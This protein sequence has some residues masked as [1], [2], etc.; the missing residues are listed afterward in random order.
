[1]VIASECHGTVGTPITSWKKWLCNILRVLH[2]IF[3]QTGA[4][5]RRKK[6]RK[7]GEREEGRNEEKEDGRLKDQEG[8]LVGRSLNEDTLPAD[9]TRTHIKDLK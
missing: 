6:G 2:Q 9:K 3:L 1:M 7:E 8:L 5:R 4:P